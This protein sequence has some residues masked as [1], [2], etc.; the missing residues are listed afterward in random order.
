MV[1]AVVTELNTGSSIRHI[2]K[3]PRFKPATRP[4]WRKVA[5]IVGLICL[6]SHAGSR[7]GI[8][9]IL[10]N[11][12]AVSILSGSCDMLMYIVPADVVQRQCQWINSDRRQAQ[13][14][15]S[16]QHQRQV[17]HRMSDNNFS[18]QASASR[19][20]GTTIWLRN[21]PVDSTHGAPEIIPRTL[22]LS[23]L[24][25]IQTIYF[26]ANSSNHIEC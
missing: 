24:H 2:A 4:P 3:V 20:I 11:T 16:S 21:S 25:A 19:D 12:L 7:K 8:L 1:G 15:K 5:S 17:D 22:N 13:V 23:R 18:D 14:G 26:I 9:S 6:I 10:T